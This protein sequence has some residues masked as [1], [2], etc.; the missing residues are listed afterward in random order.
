MNQSMQVKW[1]NSLVKLQHTSCDEHTTRNLKRHASNK[2]LQFT[3]VRMESRD[4]QLLGVPY[5][6]L[7]CTGWLLAFSETRRIRNEKRWESTISST[8]KGAIE[9]SSENRTV[10][11]LY[12]SVESSK[13]QGNKLHW[14]SIDSSL[15][16][17][18]ISSDWGFRKKS[19]LM[20]AHTI[21][22]K[23]LECFLHITPC[24]R[25]YK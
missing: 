15:H 1:M 2:V 11:L 14:K 5:L 16:W 22:K 3:R 21:F 9:R 10:A 24:W 17:L 19:D 23:E 13:Q 12:C 8:S 7:C 6:L 4:S 25:L 20:A 18:K